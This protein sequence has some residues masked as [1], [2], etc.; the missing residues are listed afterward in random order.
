MGLSDISPTCLPPCTVTPTQRGAISPE[1][2]Y[3][4]LQETDWLG[5]WLTQ[6]TEKKEE[7]ERPKADGIPPHMSGVP[8]SLFCP[9]LSLRVPSHSGISPGFNLP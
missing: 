1:P 2:P 5:Y 9:K 4:Y 7:K 8:V 6:Q 3:S